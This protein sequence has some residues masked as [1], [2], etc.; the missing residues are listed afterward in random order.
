MHNP[1]KVKIRDSRGDA[2]D[3]GSLDELLSELSSIV[4]SALDARHCVIHLLTER[5]AAEIGL[6]QRAG[7]VDN[8]SASAGSDVVNVRESDSRG[9]YTMVLERASVA[10]RATAIEV[11]GECQLSDSMFAPL[12]LRGKTI[13]IVYA[14]R[15]LKKP[16]FDAD[17][18]RL[19]ENLSLLVVKALHVNQ[20]QQLM[21]SRFTQAALTRSSEKTVR[22]IIAGSAQNPNQIAKILAKS[23][24]REMTNAGFNFSQII[25]AAS[26]IIS[27]LSNS[28]RKH[29]N[30]RN[31]RV[32]TARASDEGSLSRE[33]ELANEILDRTG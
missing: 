30:S 25:H 14:Y 5:Q 21:K 33:A 7:F 2:V 19:L 8:A 9:P 3:G 10:A 28:V 13:G 16:C 17:D 15:P 32:Q 23:F 4:A 12:L 22:E 6:R 29:K 26:E 31:R 11:T 1:D 27:E 18:L 24:Y 20:I